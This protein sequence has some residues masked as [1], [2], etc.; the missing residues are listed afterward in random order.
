MTLEGKISCVNTDPNVLRLGIRSS[1]HIEKL[2]RAAL[3]GP[4]SSDNL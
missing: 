1:R 3:G 2:H 4:A